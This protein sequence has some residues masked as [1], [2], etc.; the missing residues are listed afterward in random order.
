MNFDTPILFL[1]FNRLDTTKIV[2]E[3]IRSIKPAFLYVAAD[4]PRNELEKLKCEETRAVLN[5]IDWECELKLLFRDQ[6]LGCG[7]AVSEG[8]SWFFENEECGIILEDD[9][10]PDDSF[11]NFASTLLDKYRDDKRIWHIG[12][13]NFQ[14]EIV[15][16]HSSYYFSMF[17]H[18]WGWATWKDRWQKYKFNIENYDLQND[19][20]NYTD[21]KRIYNYFNR[22]KRQVASGTTNTWDYQWLF[23]MWQH[24]GYAIVPNQNLVTNIGFG[25]N[26]TNTKINS[27]LANIPVQSLELIHFSDDIILNKSA[28]LYTFENTYFKPLNFLRKILFRFN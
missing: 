28:D 23:C 12:G 20:N 17:A 25:N 8:I 19:L 1:I 27:F 26:A 6:N 3:K 11:F 5:E 13:N 18:I 10:L 15:R 22:R 7:K 14:D 21:D 2:F 24:Y 9:C 4:G 16:G